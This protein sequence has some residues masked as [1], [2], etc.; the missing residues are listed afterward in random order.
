MAPFCGGVRPATVH[1]EHASSALPHDIAST[2]VYERRSTRIQIAKAA[3]GDWCLRIEPGHTDKTA[4]E[5]TANASE[6]P[7]T[8]CSALQAANHW[9]AL[10]SI[11]GRV[12]RA[13]GIEHIAPKP[14]IFLN[15]GVM[16]SL[17]RCV[18]FLC[19]KRCHR[20]HRQPRTPS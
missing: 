10:A 13:M 8:Y 6:R 4:C 19:E 9:L 7:R 1:L 14:L 3:I 20:N 17:E 11:G 18:R 15:Q 2:A 12:E 5:T 16:R